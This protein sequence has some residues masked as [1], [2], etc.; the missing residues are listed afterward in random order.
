[1]YGYVRIPHIKMKGD[2]RGGRVI[3]VKKGADTAS[4]ISFLEQTPVII[5]RVSGCF[6]AYSLDEILNNS[7]I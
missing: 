2:R 5:D 7:H 6:G 3:F 4:I 1:M